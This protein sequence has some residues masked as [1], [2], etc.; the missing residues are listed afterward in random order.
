MTELWQ[1][2]LIALV[3]GGAVGVGQGLAM[4]RTTY[5]LTLSKPDEDRVIATAELTG[6]SERQV[7]KLAQ[8]LTDSSWDVAV[9]KLDREK[10]P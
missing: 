7:Y 5:R 8:Q 2:I 6:T 4:G 1:V 10:K 3:F 9:N